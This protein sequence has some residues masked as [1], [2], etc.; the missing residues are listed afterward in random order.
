M[1][2]ILLKDYIIM[3]QTTH[4][5]QRDANIYVSEFAPK[6]LYG[7]TVGS[8]GDQLMSVPFTVQIEKKNNPKL[9]NYIKDA[10]QTEVSSMV[11]N[12]IMSQYKD[13][14]E[15]EEHMKKDYEPVFEERK[16]PLAGGGFT[17]IQVEVKPDVRIAL[18]RYYNQSEDDMIREKS[19]PISNFLN[20]YY[21]MYEHGVKPEEIKV[22]SI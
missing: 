12:S 13:F 19:L 14:Y 5:T 21:S 20:W 10:K 4:Y 17:T 9:W 11:C 6:Y 22:K 18:E 8:S 16:V 3:K 15:V 2:V 7:A 1:N